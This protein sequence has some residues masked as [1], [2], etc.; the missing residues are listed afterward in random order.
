MLRGK[1]SEVVA[2]DEMITVSILNS[3]RLK[4][5]FMKKSRL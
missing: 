2:R 5:F 3:V 1:M 4:N